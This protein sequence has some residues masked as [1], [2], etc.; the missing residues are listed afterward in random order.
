MFCLT[1]L[2]S[3]FFTTKQ[4]NTLTQTTHSEGV[5]THFQ[6]LKSMQWGYW[7]YV[8]IYVCSTDVGKLQRLKKKICGSQMSRVVPWVVK[9]GESVHARARSYTI[10]FFFLIQDKI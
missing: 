2:P 8:L 10:F 1:L 6:Q 9:N 7:I 3:F 4:F 5:E